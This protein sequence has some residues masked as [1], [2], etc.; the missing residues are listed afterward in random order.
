[1]SK[2]RPKILLAILAILGLALCY[3]K[4]VA[5]PALAKGYDTVMKLLDPADGNFRIDQSVGPKQVQEALGKAPNNT[6]Q[7]GLT[8]IETYEYR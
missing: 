5:R 3:D 7:Q 2:H 8:T 1:M 4:F 6:R